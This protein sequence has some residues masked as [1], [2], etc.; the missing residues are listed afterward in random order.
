MEKEVLHGKTY[1]EI[2]TVRFANRIATYF[3]DLPEGTADIPV[4]RLILQPIIENAYIHALEKKAKHGKSIFSLKGIT[5]K[6]QIVEK[7]RRLN[8]P[9]IIA[10]LI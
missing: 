4:P 5:K 3:G 8:H 9:G 7:A 10:G 2:Q 6:R 1:M